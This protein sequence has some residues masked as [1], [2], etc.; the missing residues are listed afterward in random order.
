MRQVE[1]GVDTT[2]R[3]AF[4]VLGVLLAVLVATGLW[5]TFDYRPGVDQPLRTLHRL[6]S[7]AAV[8]VGLLVPAIAVARK[9]RAGVVVAVAFLMALIAASMTGYLLPWDQLALW[10]VTVGERWSGVLDPFG[11]GVRFVIIGGAEVG[12]DT[13]RR[14]TVVHLV[15][16]P[17][18]LVTTGG[19]LVRRFLL[20]P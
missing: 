10:A 12:I 2:I 1:D 13:Y 11:D 15:A 17:L 16:L 18:L 3:V 7:F 5:L 20:R 4:A 6:A 14:W 9:R 19:F 8:P